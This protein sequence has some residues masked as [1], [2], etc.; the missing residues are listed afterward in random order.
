MC[1]SPLPWLWGGVQIFI[2]IIGAS[3]QHVRFNSIAT[4]AVSTRGARRK[5]SGEQAGRQNQQS[6]SRAEAARG[7]HLQQ[8]TTCSLH[9][10]RGAQYTTTLTL[11][12]NGT[13][14]AQEIYTRLNDKNTKYTTKYL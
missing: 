8:L 14:A 7:E 10:A 9:L 11:R 13:T 1:L 3:V 5:Q 12:C 6:G 4:E 2:I